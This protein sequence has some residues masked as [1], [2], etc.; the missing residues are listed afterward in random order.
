[1]IGQLRHRIK[2]LAMIQGR[3]NATGAEINTIKESTEMWAKVEFQEVHSEERMTADQLTAMTTA[4]VTIRYRSGITTE[5]EVLY[6]G[7]KYK[8]LSVLEDHTRTYLT[9]E[10]VQVGAYREQALTDDDGQT[11]IDGNGNSLLFGEPVDK[12]NNY[13]P[14][15]LTFTNSDGGQFTPS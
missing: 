7:L 12:R 11:L 15:S 5:M 3:D 1:M 14:P 4:R 8:I 2:I 6:D 13:K 10:V 9:L